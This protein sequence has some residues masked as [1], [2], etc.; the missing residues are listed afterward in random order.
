MGDERRLPWALQRLGIEAYVAG[1][2]TQAAGLFEEAF[3]GFQAAG[4]PLGMAYALGIL[5]MVRHAQ[6]DRRQAAALLRESLTLHRDLQTPGSRTLLE[7]VALL[8]AESRDAERAAPLLGAVEAPFTPDGD[9][10]LPYERDMRIG[11][12]PSLVPARSRRLLR[13]GRRARSFPSRSR[14]GGPDSGR[15]DRGAVGPVRTVL[16]EGWGWIDPAR[17][18]CVAP[19]RRRPSNQE[20]AERFHFRAMARTHV[21]NILGKLDV[22]SRTAAADFAHRR[23]LI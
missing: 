22:R 17:A 10:T 6:G 14:H 7:G 4:N 5:G 2:T 8:A 21:A 11:Q 3:E 12:R 1:D 9:R 18:G 15:R 20:I 23:R 19:P 13:R 16:G